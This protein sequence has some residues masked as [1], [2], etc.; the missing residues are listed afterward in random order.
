[1]R[2]QQRGDSYVLSGIVRKTA[3]QCQASDTDV[4]QSATNDNLICLAG[5]LVNIAPSSTRPEDEMFAIRSPLRHGF[6]E[7]GFKSD[8]HSI[9]H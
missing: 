7:V 9:L 2:S 5:E 4:G 6:P 8:E 3:T 1:M